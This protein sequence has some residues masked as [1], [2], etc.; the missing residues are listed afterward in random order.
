MPDEL[1]DAA[2]AEVHPRDPGI[3]IYTSGTSANPKGVLHANG[4]PVIQSWRWGKAMGLTPDDKLLSKFPYFWSAGLTMTLGGPSRPA[5]PSSRSRAS[6]PA[7]RSRSS[8]VSG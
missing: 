5:P 2:M 6:T 3:I 4:T 8:S 7:L 1:L